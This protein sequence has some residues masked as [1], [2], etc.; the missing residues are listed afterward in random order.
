MGHEGGDF[1]GTP[2]LGVDA[3]VNL[4]K[5][6]WVFGMPSA[7]QYGFQEFPVA[8]LAGLVGEDLFCQMM[9]FDQG[10]CGLAGSWAASN[11]LLI[12]IQ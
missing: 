6:F 1:G 7:D 10:T 3:H 8:I 12:T 2:I 4:S 11:A 9:Y 5:P